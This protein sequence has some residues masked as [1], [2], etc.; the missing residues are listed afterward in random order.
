[1]R[2]VSKAAAWEMVGAQGLHVAS[3]WERLLASNPEILVPLFFADAMR[4]L[5]EAAQDHYEWQ[6]V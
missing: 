5:S 4:E 6:K 1:M 2:A 3:A